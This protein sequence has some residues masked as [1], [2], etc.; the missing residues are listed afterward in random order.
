MRVV[1]GGAES[2]S[3]G[4]DGGVGGPQMEVDPREAGQGRGPGARRKLF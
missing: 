3:K 2:L 1:Q 4:G